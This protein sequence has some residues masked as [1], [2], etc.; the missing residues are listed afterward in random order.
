M[1]PAAR[2]LIAVDDPIIVNLISTMLQRKGYR[3]AGT[4]ATSED[5]LA[6]TV[7]LAPDLVVMDVNLTGS[8]DA[9]DAAH[10]IFQLFH[11]PVVFI[12]ATSEETKVARIA[13]AQPYGILFKPFAAIELTAC[14]DLALSNHADRAGMLG[15]LPLGDPRKMMD[16]P[17]E[18]IIVL[19][20]RGRIILLNLSAAWFVDRDARQVLLKHWR[21]IMM[22]VSDANGEEIK[23][24]VTAATKDKAGA[25]YDSSTSIVTTTS[26]RRKVIL[27]IRPIQDSHERLIASVMSLKENKKTYM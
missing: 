2:I 24:P 11:V 26:K 15:K 16:N 27:T 1:P 19:D 8:M 4:I 12:A 6:K 23:D 13:Y 25:I 14:V 10:Y 17:D 9:I 3:I 22:F 20:K 18:A 7:D 21:D 5:T